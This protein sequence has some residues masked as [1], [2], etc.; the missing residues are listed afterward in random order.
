[1]NS[2][3]STYMY[4]LVEGYCVSTYMYVLVEGYC[5]QFCQSH[6][7]VSDGEALQH[8][9]NTQLGYGSV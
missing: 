7:K 6:Y 1:M 2:S 5:E 4:V 9:R 3:V 8:T